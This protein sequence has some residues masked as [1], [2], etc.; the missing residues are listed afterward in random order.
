M[1]VTQ[2]WVHDCAQVYYAFCIDILVTTLW[3]GQR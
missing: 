3:R 1:K 2:E